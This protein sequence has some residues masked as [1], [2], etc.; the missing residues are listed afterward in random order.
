LFFY[1][2]FFLPY[3]LQYQLVDLSEDYLTPA[4]EEKD[5]P[6]V[7]LMEEYTAEL[8][9]DNYLARYTPRKHPL[10]VAFPGK[11]KPEFVGA[12]P[13]PAVNACKNCHAAAVKVWENSKHAQAYDTLVKAKRPSN[14]EFDPECIVCHTVG[15]GYD[16]GFTDAKKTPHL[17]NVGCES[18]H[19]PSSEHVTAETGGNAADK[20]TWRK[21]I[22]P[23]KYLPNE[24]AHRRQ[25]ED[26]CIKCHDHENDVGWRG[27]KA[28]E[29]KWKWIDHLKKP[30]AAVPAAA[31]QPPK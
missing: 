31:K 19:G 9:R 22:N 28:F 11:G 24:K 10:Q 15:F 14:R 1:F 2:L 20:T 7:K 21:A 6:V 23:W 27:D 30:A 5:H 17:L 4:A 13:A 3:K 12:E 25:M 26:M 18:C 29:E 16:S 8:K